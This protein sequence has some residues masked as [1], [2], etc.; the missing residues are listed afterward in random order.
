[1]RY[2]FQKSGDAVRID[3]EGKFTFMD[4]QTFGR[5]LREIAKSPKNV[6]IVVNVTRL[7][8]IDASGMEMLMRV[9]DEAKRRHSPLVFG[10]PQ[11]QVMLALRQA[12]AHT[13]LTIAA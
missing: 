9:C 12:A 3:M 8:S 10:Q 11:G 1:M 4:S 2:S 7:E 6:E 5:L 13:P